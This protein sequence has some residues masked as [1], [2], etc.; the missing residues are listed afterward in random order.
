MLPIACI[1]AVFIQSVLSAKTIIDVLSEDKKYETLLS[2]LERYQLIEYVKQIES[3]TFFAPDNNAFAQSNS[4]IDRSSLLYHIIKKGMSSKDFYHGQL[5]ETLLIRPGYLVPDNNS[6]AGQRIK[7]TREGTEI[8]VNQAKIIQSDLQVNNKTLIHTIDSVLNPPSLIGD[9]ITKDTWIHRWMA[10]TGL[11]DLLNQK[12]P[13]TL[14]LTTASNPLDKFNPIESSYLTSPHGQQDLALF[15]QYALIDKAIFL[16]EFNAGKTTYK[17]LSGDALVLTSDKKSM[18]I[19]DMPIQQYDIIAANGVIHEIS[20]TFRPPSIAFDTRKYLY[21]S[22]STHMVDLMDSYQISHHYLNNSQHNFTFLIPSLETINQSIV[23]KDWLEYHILHQPFSYH[24][25]KGSYLLDS[26]FRSPELGYHCQKLLAQV[27]DHSQSIYFDRARVIGES[28]NINQDVIYQLS[29]PVTVPGKLLER[30]VLDLE[31]STFIATLYVSEV[32]EEIKNTPGLTLFVPTNQAFQNLGLV[33]KY[34]VHPIAKSQLQTVLRYHAAPTLLYYDDMKQPIIQLPTLANA[35]LNIIQ[36]DQT[37]T[38][39]SSAKIMQHDVL[40]SNGVIHKISEVQMP[41]GLNITNR[42]VLIGIESKLMMQVL[43]RTGLLS[44]IDQPD[45]VV[46]APSDKAFAHLDVEAL[47]NDHVQLERIAKLHIVPTAWQDRWIVEQHKEDR[48]NEYA[49]LLSEDDKVAIRENEK[50]ELFA[51]VKNGGDNNRAH[52]IGLGRVPA[53]GGVIEIDTVLMPIRRGLFG[54]P[55]A[56]SI[57][58]LLM[59][60]VLT[61][62]IVAVIGFFGYKIHNRRRLGYRPIS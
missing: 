35:T 49:T 34:L 43:E 21:G 50:G 2:Y 33:A 8:F 32:I 28:I 58:V 15:F 18:A 59:V 55:F 47:F 5:K 54:L 24:D 20:Q 3:G 27:E 16:D 61:S 52:V 31:V 38:V 29:E 56:W 23:S 42:N 26:E 9:M 14:F 39:G 45:R 7:M 44:A 62:G 37:V 22:N 6:G 12:K 4:T 41:P 60:I 10:S 46:L 48:R 51:E 40:V 30:L 13:F 17:S 11:L 1:L 19:N 25:K 57:V 36:Q 53:G